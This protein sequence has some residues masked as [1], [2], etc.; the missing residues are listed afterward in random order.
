MPSPQRTRPR[1]RVARRD[2][3]ARMIQPSA[4]GT[5]EARI[6]LF[7]PNLPPQY[8]PSRQPTIEPRL[9]LLAEINIVIIRLTFVL[10][11]V[12]GNTPVFLIYFSIFLVMKYLS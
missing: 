3:E 1:M 4:A 5:Q 2:E 8:P 7:G 9:M 6:V 11:L 10:S 12:F